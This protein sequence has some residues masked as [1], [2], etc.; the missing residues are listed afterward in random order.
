MKKCPFCAEDINAEA[1]KCKHC[2]SMLEANPLA[3]DDVKSVATD[4]ARI[5][6]KKI[7][8]GVVAVC[9]LISFVFLLIGAFIDS[10][11]APGEDQTLWIL[12][13]AVIFWVAPFLT[14]FECSFCGEGNFVFKPSKNKK[15]SKCNTLHIIDW[16]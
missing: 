13:P 2:G 12:I 8:F 14:V 4:K 7:D 1:V 16:K 10:D 11:R 6:L 9:Y 15:C 5:T 3:R